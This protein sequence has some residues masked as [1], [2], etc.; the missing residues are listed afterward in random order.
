MVEPMPGLRR[1]SLVLLMSAGCFS[2]PPQAGA[3]GSSGD[4]SPTGTTTVATTAGA[5]TTGQSASSSGDAPEGSSDASTSGFGS[6]G[7]GS[8]SGGSETTNPPGGCGDG[9]VTGIELCDTDDLAGRSCETFGFAEGEL[10]CRPD[11]RY[12]FASCVPPEGM[13]FVP[14]GPFTMGSMDHADEQPVREVTLSPYFIDMYEVTAAAYQACMID[15]GCDAP[16][17]T[18]NTQFDGQCNVGQ[19]GR[20]NHPANCVG[21]DAAAAY[22]TWAQKRLPTEAEW[23]KA[24]RGMDERRYPW[25]NAPVPSCSHAISGQGGP[26][27]GQGSTAPVGSVPMGV[28]PYGAH[29]MAGNVWEWVSDYYAATYDGADLE[30][31]SGPPSSDAR[32]LRGGGWYQ[33]DTA[34]FTTTR[35]HDTNLSLSDAFIGFRCARPSPMQ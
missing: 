21:H 22:C 16:M 6:T 10:A 11:C 12:D 5:D 24:A 13:V 9:L 19:A 4:P 23:E 34:E 2:D 1:V 28:S 3:L 30:D 20:E 31:P 8:S 32:I 15:G 17:S 25:G 29:D 26:G 27:C 33:N 18:A 35:R 7:W 14:P